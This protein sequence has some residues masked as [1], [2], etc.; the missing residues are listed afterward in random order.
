VLSVRRH[1][2]AIRRTERF[3]P[4]PV[5]RRGAALR[6]RPLLRREK[7]VS[8]IDESLADHETVLYRARFHPLIA[9][10]AW[11]MFALLV[12]LA[13]YLW[14][15]EHT[16]A[17]VATVLAGAALLVTIMYPV[18]SQEVAITNRRI[19]KS[20]GIVSR[21][22]EELQLDAIE[23]IRV[24]QTFFGRVLKYGRVVVTGKGERVVSLPSL[25]Y[26]PV[27]LRQA[28]Q[29]AITASVAVVP[30]VVAPSEPPQTLLAS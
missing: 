11:S 17:A 23:E 29:N 30:T 14:L 16:V 3:P 12:T 20:R 15:N 13:G 24:E 6:R 8:Y 1:A 7:N 5:S 28:L 2:I 26:D 25:L 21:A 27:G 9:V 10:S 18:W 4:P 19:A 22:T